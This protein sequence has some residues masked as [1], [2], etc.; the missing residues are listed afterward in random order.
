MNLPMKQWT[1]LAIFLLIFGLL[2]CRNPSCDNVDCGEFGD[3]IELTESTTCRCESGYEEDADELCNVKSAI[4]FV[5]EWEAID[6]RFDNINFTVDTLRYDVSIS[7]D[8]SQANRIRFSKLGNLDNSSCSFSE[9]ITLLATVSIRSLNIVEATFCPGPQF[10]GYQISRLNGDDFITD[11][12][13]EININFRLTFTDSQ[14]P[15]DFDADIV[16]LRK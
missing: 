5:G 13:D 14:G 15:K 10:S 11:E 6:A 12:D 9:P 4:R 8:P 3:C 7:E 2:S 16:L 1:Y